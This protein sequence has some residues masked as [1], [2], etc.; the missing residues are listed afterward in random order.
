MKD[1]SEKGQLVEYKFLQIHFK[2]I[3]EWFDPEIQKY[4]IKVNEWNGKGYPHLY[5]FESM[6]NL[7][8]LTEESN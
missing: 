4:K 6:D 7:K 5:R 3:V 2:G 1:Y 8:F